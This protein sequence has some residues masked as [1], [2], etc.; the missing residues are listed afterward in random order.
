[1]LS[2]LSR[3][4]PG[5]SLLPGE[6]GLD[7]STD[8]FERPVRLSATGTA[9]G[10]A[11]QEGSNLSLAVTTRARL[12]DEYAALSERKLDVRIG[13]H[14]KVEDRVTVR[15][16]PGYRVKSAPSDVAIDTRFGSFAVKVEQLDKQITVT[17]HVAV[18]VSRVAPDDYQAWR[19]FCQAV[20]VAMG[21][22]LVLAR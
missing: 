18:K 7:A 15:I 21:A 19:A 10:Y 13:A 1:V 14:G 9:P 5:L 3:E 16:P 2:D 17:S 12:L 4:F 20:E 8:D 6:R 11:R 22:R